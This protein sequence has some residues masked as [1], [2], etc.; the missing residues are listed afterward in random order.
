MIQAIVFDFDGVIVDTEPLHHQAF[1]KALDDHDIRF[2]FETYRQRYIGFD[3]RDGLR[4][5][6][7]DHDVALSNDELTERI[8]RKARAFEQLSSGDLKPLPGVVELAEAAA[9]VMPVGLCSGA[10]RSDIECVLP[11]LDGGRLL[12][13]FKAWVTADDVEKSKPDPSSYALSA[14]RLGQEPHHCLAIED[15]PTGLQSAH[16]AGFQ[17][18][19][20]SQLHSDRQLAPW[21]G[22]YV[23]S[24]AEVDLQTLQQWYP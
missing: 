1:L 23:Q 21:A 20:V 9:A 7:R 17:T 13:L 15:T 2:D 24:L 3:D 14:V 19:G 5:I 11:N 22:R 18:L 6:C 16:D 12:P 10:L 8:D 4:A